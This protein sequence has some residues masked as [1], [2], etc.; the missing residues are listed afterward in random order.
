M[1]SAASLQPKMQAAVH[2]STGELS[3]PK[4]ALTYLQYCLQTLA[5]RQTIKY[6]PFSAEGIQ[7]NSGPRAVS[8]G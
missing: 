6:G 1:C 2:R 3:M 4:K 5:V 8:S 7:Q